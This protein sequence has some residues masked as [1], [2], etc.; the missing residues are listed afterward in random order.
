MIGRPQPPIGCRAGRFVTK[1]MRIWL[2]GG[3]TPSSAHWPIKGEFGP[4]PPLHRWKEDGELLDEPQLPPHRPAGW[5]NKRAQT[6]TFHAWYPGC[7]MEE[8]A[9]G[10]P[11]PK[12]TRNDRAHAA[13][14]ALR[15]YGRPA[16]TA[17][18]MAA[19]LRPHPG[20]AA[21]KPLHRGLGFT[22]G[23]LDEFSGPKSSTCRWSAIL[24]DNGVVWPV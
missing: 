21:A 12:D 4:C 14:C 5:V 11:K 1:V 19:A 7:P 6:L 24:N 22:N 9:Y 8:D 18:A 15:G 16:A 20:H 3:P 23:Y 17:W 13:V 10:I 2:G